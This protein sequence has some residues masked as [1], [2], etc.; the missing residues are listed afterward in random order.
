MT[1]ETE[2]LVKIVKESNNIVFFGGAG[3]STESGI[4]DFRS[5]NGLY[6]TG[7]GKK[8]SPEKI[9]S[10]SFF[11]RNTLDFFTYYKTQ[12]IYKDA[13]PNLAHDALAKLEELGKLT[14]VITQNI[15]NLHQ[16]AGSKT[17]YELHGSSNRNYCMKC[18]KS[19]SLGQIMSMDIV[20]ICTDCGGVIKPDVV[21]YEE[22]L[23]QSVVKEAIQ[24][25][26]KADTM[27]V[28]GTS[29]VVWPAASLLEYF[30]GHN[31]VLINKSET[32]YDT[33][34]S[35]VIQDSIGEV[36]NTVIKNILSSE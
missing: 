5:E 13:K 1:K 22:E 15:D 34:A 4:P 26:Q 8:Y 31:L 36:L 25:I 30:N 10:H 23:N 12:M 18:R 16:M 32:S 11:M 29:L 17:V 3:V 14:A 7:Q 33:R 35:L 9:L 2:K 20:P 6:T 21:L 19:Y 24:A 27:I 28:G